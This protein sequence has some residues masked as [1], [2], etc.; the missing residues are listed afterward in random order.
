MGGFVSL[1]EMKKVGERVDFVISE[2]PLDVG[3]L[4]ELRQEVHP[5][6]RYAVPG[7]YAFV[8][9]NRCAAPAV[10]ELGSEVGDG[11][12]CGG[13]V[14]DIQLEARNRLAQRDGGIESVPRMRQ[15]VQE[16]GHEMDR[17]GCTREWAQASKTGVVS[18]KKDN[19]RQGKRFMSRRAIQAFHRDV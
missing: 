9:T 5:G 13:Q 3:H 2:V 1:W 19:R 17:T 12:H 11:L 8:R 14:R 6:E 15:T 4:R 10:A 16:V 18:S 7:N